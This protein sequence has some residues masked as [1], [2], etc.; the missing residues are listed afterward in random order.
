MLTVLTVFYEYYK[1]YIYHVPGICNLCRT[2]VWSATTL[3]TYIIG[4]QDDLPQ[5][6][7]LSLPNW[8]NRVIKNFLLQILN[9]FLSVP[10]FLKVS[11]LPLENFDNCDVLM[12]QI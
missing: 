5:N 4:L 1:L 8:K 3:S 12:E 10:S 6:L 7:S 11:D 9:D 2:T